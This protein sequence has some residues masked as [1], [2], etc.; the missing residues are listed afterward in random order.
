VGADVGRVGLLGAAV[1]GAEVVGT[2]VLGAGV[3][4]AGVLGANVV[5]AGVLGAGVD[6]VGVVGA[7]V[8][9]ASSKGMKFRDEHASNSGSMK[10]APSSATNAHQVQCTTSGKKKICLD[11]A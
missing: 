10:N 4:G 1:V 3:V 11:T 7:D 9:T 2:D 8:L 6:G 5:G